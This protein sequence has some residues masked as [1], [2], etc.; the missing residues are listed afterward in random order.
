MLFR[1][2]GG[3]SASEQSELEEG[4]S[5]DEG[6]FEH[7]GRSTLLARIAEQEATIATLE[8]ENLRWVGLGGGGGRPRNL[9][10][11]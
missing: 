9:G 3:D 8:D 6:G 2:R 7:A 5:D 10:P 4:P 1:P 11:G